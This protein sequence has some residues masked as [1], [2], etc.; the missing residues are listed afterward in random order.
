MTTYEIP[1]GDG[2]TIL[3]TTHNNDDRSGFNVQTVGEIRLRLAPEGS[4]HGKSPYL[5]IDTWVSHPELEVLKTWDVDS[6]LLKVSTPK[7]EE[8]I[9][10]RGPYCISLEITAWFP[11]ETVLTDILIESVTLGLRVM[12]DIDVYISNRAKL[13]SITGHI[14]FPEAR[15]NFLHIQQ[16]ISSE[17]Q[18]LGMEISPQPDFDIVP[19]ESRKILVETVTGAITGC[20]PLMDFL[21]VSS[22]SGSIKINIVPLAASEESPA[23]ADLEIQTSSGSIHAYLPL[24]DEKYPDFAP[25]PRD[26]ITRVHSSSGSVTGNFYLGSESNFRSTTGSM[27]LVALP[28]LQDDDAAKS[29]FETH[30]ISGSINV[31]VKDPIFISPLS[32]SDKKPQPELFTP[33]GSNDPYLIIPPSPVPGLFSISPPSQSS[34]SRKLRTLKS[35]HSANSASVRVSYPSSWEGTVHQKTVSGSIATDGDGLR[36]VKARKGYAYME[37]KARKGV[38]SDTEGCWVEMGDVAGSLT[39]LVGREF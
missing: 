15:D 24:R 39:F 35:T 21:G 26:Y 4:V 11:A 3:Q 1:V 34:E 7:F 5:T 30:T 12:E 14:W 31:V 22:Q 23:P 25:P 17:R 20:Y 29:T 37:V 8:N 27:H 19:F 16:P 6:R 36:V 9:G 32:M 10:R 28:V 18:S 13:T 38:E 33:I 2:L